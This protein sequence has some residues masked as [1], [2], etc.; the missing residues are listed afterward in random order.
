MPSPNST[1]STSSNKQ[2]ATDV[3]AELRD[4]ANKAVM[5]KDYEQAAEAPT[6]Y[7]AK[8]GVELP[9]SQRDQRENS[10]VSRM[11]FNI[12]GSLYILDV[13]LKSNGDTQE[14]WR[15]GKRALQLPS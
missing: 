10:L 9:I 11:A 13:V 7:D 14:I 8:K 1:S 5:N 15:R 4:A 2:P 12:D 6:R 3:A